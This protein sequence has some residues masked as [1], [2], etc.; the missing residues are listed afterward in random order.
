MTILQIA[1]ICYGANSLLAVSLGEDDGTWSVATPE[2]RACWVSGV[3]KRLHDPDGSPSGRHAAWIA[4]QEADGWTHGDTFDIAAK[5][6]P[7]MVPFD[8]LSPEQQAK[9]RLFFATVD[10]LRKLMY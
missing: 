2:E 9:D 3:N 6:D 8:E 10:A 5:T 4:S 1:S 7:N